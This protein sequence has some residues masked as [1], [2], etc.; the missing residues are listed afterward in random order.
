MNKLI[1][2]ITLIICV[3]LIGCTQT[4]TEQIPINFTCADF[5]VAR[6]FDAN[7]TNS[8]INECVSVCENSFNGFSCVEDSI[9]CNCG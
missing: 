9:T 1:I 4:S 8:V 6:T 3:L 2:L 5:E 7:I